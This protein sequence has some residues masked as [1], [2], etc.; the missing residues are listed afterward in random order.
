MSKVS[1]AV[2]GLALGDGFGFITE[3][4]R[5]PE[6]SNKFGNGQPMPTES[7][8]TISDDTQ[9]S[10][11]LIESLMK[12]N[13]KHKGINTSDSRIPYVAREFVHL[14][15]SKKLRG[16]G[17]A[18]LSSL[19][20]LSQTDLSDPY[21]GADVSSVGSGTVMRSPW[22]GLGNIVPRD[23]IEDFSNSQAKITHGSDLAQ[24]TAFL[25]ALTTKAIFQD[26][27]MPGGIKEFALSY[28]N[29]AKKFSPVWEFLAE[30]IQMIDDLPFGWESMALESFDLS[31]HLG[32]FGRC[33]TV[34][35]TAIAIADAFGECDPLYA[36]Q[37]G[38]FTGGDSDT[39]NAVVGAFVGAHH[40]DNIWG[41]LPEECL[42][43]SYYYRMDKI[44][45]FI[46]TY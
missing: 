38:M 3:R 46:E 23:L 15:Q 9:M 41:R 28:C 21:I 43:E 44:I 26:H 20:A 35:V 29:Y 27:I 6:I 12:Y 42:E 4:M 40:E 31:E 32:R 34:L 7:T 45:D 2:Y 39:I 22:V 19:E 10:I 37:R 1:N 5:F 33:D 36:L 8:L 13:D 11:V 30:Q 18:T 14:Y 25:T 16:A 24:H 17:K